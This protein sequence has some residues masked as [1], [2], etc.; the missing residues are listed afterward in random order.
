M[1]AKKSCKLLLLLS[2]LFVSW[3]F[4]AE[5]YKVTFGD[6]YI[7]AEKVSALVRPLIKQ[8]ADSYKEDALLMEAIV[9]P[10]LMRY[11]RLFDAL[12]TGSLVSLYTRF[13]EAY[14]DFSI[15]YFQMKPSFAESLEHYMQEKHF[16][17]AKELGFLSLDLSDSFEGRQTRVKRLQDQEWQVKY[18]IA[19]LKCLNSR[20]GS[21]ATMAPS[22]RVRWT[23]AAYNC[24]WNL[25][26][27]KIQSFVNEK[28]Y[29][30]NHWDAAVKYAYADIAAYRFQELTK[31]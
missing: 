29:H 30:L 24:G 20:E 4:P 19:F 15:G 7:R 10:E 27:D 22:K 31:F 26:A 13:G 9:F 11:S 6:A 18:L 3:R 28:Y 2:F 23:A 1:H 12:E 8:Y 17:W 5:D 16:N 14:A 21:L 25:P